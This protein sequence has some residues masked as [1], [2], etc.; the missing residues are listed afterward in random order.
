MK[1]SPKDFM[2]PKDQAALE[3]LK[4]RKIDM[5]VSYYGAD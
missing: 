4:V 2:H 3:H 5:E 1:L